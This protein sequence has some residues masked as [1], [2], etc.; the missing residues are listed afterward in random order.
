MRQ[1][2]VP[3]KFYLRRRGG[4]FFEIETARLRLKNVLPLHAVILKLGDEVFAEFVAPVREMDIVK[5]ARP[6][7]SHE[8]GVE[9]ALA[10]AVDE[11]SDY[12]VEH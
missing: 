3:Q 10:D 5:T 1:F 2:A 8:G 12:C 9:F 11:V 6:Q 4:P 7:Q